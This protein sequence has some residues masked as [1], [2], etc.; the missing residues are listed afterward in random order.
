MFI[1]IFITTSGKKEADKIS[2]RLIA[3][4]L[5]AC[6]NVIEGASSLFW[7]ENKVDRAREA[8]MIVKSKR[9]KLP[10]IIKLVKS[11]HSYEVP[12]IIALPII[13]GERKYLRWLDESVKPHRRPA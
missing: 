6:V 4:K 12:E 1:V 8:L 10:A 11:L 9:T 7:W 3:E 13:G 2:E 5:A